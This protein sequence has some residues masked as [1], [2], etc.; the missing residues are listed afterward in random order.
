MQINWKSMLIK[1]IKENKKKNVMNMLFEIY[2][3]KNNPAQIWLT[4][5]FKLLSSVNVFAA[6][7]DMYN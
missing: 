2:I 4:C 6:I 1:N 5:T 7:S 3:H